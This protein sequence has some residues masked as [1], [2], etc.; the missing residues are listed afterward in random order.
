MIK[1]VSQLAFILGLVALSACGGGGSGGSSGSGQGTTSG[2]TNTSTSGPDWTTVQGNS[3]HTG[4]VAATYNT[5]QFAH[6]WDWQRPASGKSTN[7]IN[8][9]ATGDG[10]V[11]I[12]NDDYNGQ[13]TLFALK[14]ADGTKAWQDDFGS[15]VN[16]SAPAY[17]NGFVY[18]QVAPD[19][20]HVSLYALNA[21]TGAIAWQTPLYSSNTTDLATPVVDGNVVFLGMGISVNTVF[22]FNAANGALLWQAAP[23]SAQYIRGA[24]TPAVD[25]SKVYFYNGRGL[26]VFARSTG[27]QVST[28]ADNMNFSQPGPYYGAPIL[29]PNGDVILFHGTT[30]ATTYSG[31]RLNA[32]YETRELMNYFLGTGTPNSSG[33]EDATQHFSVT[34]AVANGVVYT[35]INNYSFV[36]GITIT[37][38]GL[39]AKG[40]K[41]DLPLWSWTGASGGLF[42]NNVI[43]TNNLVFL[44]S[45]TQTFA[46]DIT[47]HA[48]V[49]SY[50]KG[51]HLALGNNILYI[52]TGGDQSDGGLTAIRLN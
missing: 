10:R 21:S 47:S 29:Q 51:G 22:A 8:P 4:Y 52:G 38:G 12:T 25:S 36:G 35:A 28:R 3:A 9:I 45:A 23:S 39:L 49:W 15:T 24:E 50:P 27:A 20:N 13:G 2:G 26:D 17:G 48:A 37:P 44:S 43:A 6:L 33:W 30:D 5:S 18:V 32:T 11:Y 40:A 7:Y 41:D 34:P 31:R 1:S 19:L 42:Y 14:S 16:V 46:I